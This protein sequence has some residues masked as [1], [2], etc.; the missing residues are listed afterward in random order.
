MWAEIVFLAAEFSAIIEIN[1][2]HHSSHSAHIADIPMPPL[3]CASCG[4]Y[5]TTGSVNLLDESFPHRR[6]HRWIMCTEPDASHWHVIQM[7][8]LQFIVA[9]VIYYYRSCFWPFLSFHSIFIVAGGYNDCNQR[10]HFEREPLLLLMISTC[11]WNPV[12]AGRDVSASVSHGLRWLLRHTPVRNF[13]NREVFLMTGKV[14]F[15]PNDYFFMNK[16]NGSLSKLLNE[17]T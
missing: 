5:R 6:G 14:L 7:T 11:L 9:I 15:Q 16:L 12:S 8:L 1:Y 3:V 17:P 2:C 4:G 13:Q 10:F